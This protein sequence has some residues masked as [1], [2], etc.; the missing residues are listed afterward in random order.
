M[1]KLSFQTYDTRKAAEYCDLSVEALQEYRSQGTG[2]EYCQCPFTG[3]WRY[4]VESLNRWLTFQHD[5]GANSSAHCLNGGPFRNVPAKQITNLKQH[6]V[7]IVTAVSGGV[8]NG[9]H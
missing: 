8:N 5:K 4:I 2:P 1:P 3:D 7:Y 6:S 9:D